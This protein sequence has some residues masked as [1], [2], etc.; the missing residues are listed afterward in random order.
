L[1]TTKQT[2]VSEEL[3]G[4]RMIPNVRHGQKQVGGE[5]QFE[6][7]DG[8]FDDL[9]EAVLGGTWA[10]NVLKAGTARKSFSMLRHFADLQSGDKP[11]HLFTGCELNTLNLTIP[12]GGIIT[13]SF[14]VIGKSQ[15]PGTTAPAGA[16]LGSA[17]TT[18]PFDSFTGTLKEGGVTSAIATEITLTLE[19][20]LE[21]RFAIGDDEVISQATI[22]RSNLSGQATFFFENATLLEKFLN[23]TESSLEIDL[24][25]SAANTLELLIPA[26]KYNGGNTDTA[27]GGEILIPCPFQAFYDETVGSNFRI[28]RSA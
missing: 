25:D 11:Y 16:V 13:G 10:T 9:L 28:T 3:T 15:T 18:E 2:F 23:E 5:I 20:A 22:G 27:G 12:T 17:G 8:S 24:T 6:L 7:S 19:N 21:P 1:A 26:L 4:D 14:G